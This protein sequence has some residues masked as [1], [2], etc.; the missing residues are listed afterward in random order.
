MLTRFAASKGMRCQR[1]SQGCRP[2][3][4]GPALMLIL[5]LTMLESA[6]DGEKSRNPYKHAR[7]GR[8]GKALVTREKKKPD[9]AERKAVLEDYRVPREQWNNCVAEYRVPISLGG[10]NA[11]ANIEVLRKEEA[12]LKRRVQDDVEQKVRRKEIGLEEAQMRILNWR[13]DPLALGKPE[14]GR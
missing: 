14:P 13:A 10:S 1:L 8:D 4:V 3:L 9:R 6:A 5:F 7:Q 2:G 12:R 11:Y